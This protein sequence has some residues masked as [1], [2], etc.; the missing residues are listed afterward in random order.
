MLTCA[1]YVIAMSLVRDIRVKAYISKCSSVLCEL[2]PFFNSFQCCKVF[3][4]PKRCYRGIFHFHCP[5][6]FNS[7]TDGDERRFHYRAFKHF[8]CTNKIVPFIWKAA[9]SSSGKHCL[10]NLFSY[11]IC[12]SNHG[13]VIS[14]MSYASGLSISM[15][16][17]ISRKKDK[18]IAT[19]KCIDELFL[20]FVSSIF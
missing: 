2:V 17:K 19:P 13:C 3:Q 20:S 6:K 8:P 18:K 5:L 14:T 7:K 16:N 11:V 10:C 1:D 12:D 15:N 9:F 4:K